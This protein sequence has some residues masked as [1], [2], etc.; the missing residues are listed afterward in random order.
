[1]NTSHKKI[2]HPSLQRLHVFLITHFTVAENVVLDFWHLSD[3]TNSVIFYTL[4]TQSFHHHKPIGLLL[5]FL[6]IDQ[7]HLVRHAQK[8]N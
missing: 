2:I 4:S 3:R 1:M 7:L 8:H 6:N 5:N